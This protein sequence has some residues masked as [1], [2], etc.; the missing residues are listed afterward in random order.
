M[1]RNLTLLLTLIL[2]IASAAQAAERP[3]VVFI[4]V[5]DMNCDSV[6]AF[7]CKVGNITPN[8][9]K[10]A[11]EGMKFERA[12]VTIA[13][14]QPTRAVWM[15]GRYPQQNGALG[16]DII[17]KNVP[18]LVEALS[19]AGYYTGLFA[20]TRHV[21]P[22]RKE[23]WDVIVAGKEFKNGRDPKAYHQQSAAFFEQ[24]AKAD[25]P[26]FLMACSQDPHRPFARSAENRNLQ[27]SPKQPDVSHAYSKDDVIVPKFLPDLPNVRLEIAQ[28]FTSVHRADET[29]GAVLQ[30]LDESGQA[31]N[32]LVVFMSD[33][34]MALPFAKTNCYYH[35]NRTPW[36]VRWPKVVKAGSVDSKHMISGIDLAPTIL[37][38]VGL[39]PLAGQTGRST[40]PL[41]KGE[42]QADRDQ[43]F[44][45]INRTS[46]RNEYAMDSVVTPKFGYI[47][48]AWSNGETVFKNESQAGHTMKA[49]KAAAKTNEKIAARVKLFLYRVPEEL[50]D[51]ETDPDALH[52][53]AAD[54]EY[55]E[56][57]KKLRAELL[58]YMIENDDPQ[59]EAFE[60]FLNR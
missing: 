22:T 20:K 28:Y 15:T 18:T 30:A 27:A 26:F 24:A 47:F 56:Q 7:G 60:A 42:T 11:S 44:L 43:V 6:G 32:T 2:A 49:M 38:A 57:L 17:N 59:R 51:Y 4:N 45:Q 12:F 52:N 50:Y 5:D 55:V 41:L 19:E 58:E 1:T 34:G 13:I 39:K 23:T 33:H 10:L 36:I 16:F 21:V 53:L 29:V 54:P 25:K 9:D 31:D 3:N 35:S 8:I 40:L 48:N 46:G 37:D 14:C